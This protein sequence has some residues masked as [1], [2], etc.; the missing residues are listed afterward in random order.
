MPAQGNCYGSVT[1]SVTNMGN[2][3]IDHVWGPLVVNLEGAGLQ[4]LR[5]NSAVNAT[6]VA[7][8]YTASHFACKPCSKVRCQQTL[9]NG[10]RHHSHE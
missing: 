6:V 5:A 8:M 7:G 9:N 2:S 4:L 1:F 3:S 10:S